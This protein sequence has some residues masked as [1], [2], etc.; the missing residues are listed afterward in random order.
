MQRRSHGHAG[1]FASYCGIH[2]HYHACGG[3]WR[4]VSTTYMLE[5]ALPAYAEGNKFVIIYP[6]SSK[7]NNPE[8][9]ECFDWSGYTTP[10]FDT[11]QGIQLN[12]VLN[13]ITKLRVTDIPSL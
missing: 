11:R 1:S 13:M 9:D 7:A 12:T 8:T 2:V 5:N 10:L 3:G 4:D 6:Q